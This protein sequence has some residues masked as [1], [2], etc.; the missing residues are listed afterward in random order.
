VS[1]SC[2]FPHVLSLGSYFRL[3]IQNYRPGRFTPGT[4]RCP[5]S[6]S[7]TTWDLD[8]LEIRTW[9]VVIDCQPSV[10]LLTISS[11]GTHQR[12]RS[13]ATVSPG[14]Y[15]SHTPGRPCIFGRR[16][17]VTSEETIYNLSCPAGMDQV[18]SARTDDSWRC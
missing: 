2:S 11:G 5:C 7:C 10:T 17:V 12:Q 3:A 14:H 16:C 9:Y 6:T 1:K 4:F 8:Y 15:I 18:T 13:D